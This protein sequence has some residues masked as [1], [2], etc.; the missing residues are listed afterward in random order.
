[1]DHMHESNST[2]SGGI[3]NAHN[4][5]EKIHRSIVLKQDRLR[6]I[7]HALDV[8]TIL[9]SDLIRSWYTELNF[10]SLIPRPS[11]VSTVGKAWLRGYVSPDSFVL[12]CI[13]KSAQ[14]LSEQLSR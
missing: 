9:Q 14:D 11:H 2:H 10:T 12:V 7:K 1:M 8:N 6:V 3:V 4:R 5:H 13:K